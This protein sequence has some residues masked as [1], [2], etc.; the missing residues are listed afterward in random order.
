MLNYKE[1]I[2]PQLAPTKLL[3]SSHLDCHFIKLDT[4]TITA[5]GKHICSMLARRGT[6]SHI[7]RLTC[8][9]N[10]KNILARKEGLEERKQGLRCSLG[11]G[12]ASG[13]PN[14]ADEVAI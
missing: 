13:G 3:I 10:Q 5:Q 14:A 7:Y 4:K 6:C 8:S 2:K 12:R 11:Q 1:S 9:V